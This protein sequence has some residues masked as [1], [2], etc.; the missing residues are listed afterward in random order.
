[1]RFIIA[2]VACVLVIGCPG[3]E[4]V[5]PC[6]GCLPADTRAGD[7]DVEV[8]IAAPDV[9]HQYH[10]RILVAVGGG[11]LYAYHLCPDGSGEIQAPAG[12]DALWAGDVACPFP[13]PDCENATMR[14]RD[15]SFWMENGFEL[16]AAFNG[17]LTG[18]GIERRMIVRYRG[19]K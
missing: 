16:A 5:G 1:M 8:E 4:P 7:W 11:A 2:A 10:S 3:P 9:F 6:D 19:R 15:G 17:T 12:R 18:C 13:A 14:L